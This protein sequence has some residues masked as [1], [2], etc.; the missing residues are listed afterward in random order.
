MQVRN[1]FVVVLSVLVFCGVVFAQTPW[2]DTPKTSTRDHLNQPIDSKAFTGIFDPSRIKMSHQ[3]GMSYS[4][5]GGSGITQGYY[6]NTISYRF[7][8]PVMLRMRLGVTN[9]PFAD[10]YSSGPG[11]SGMQNILQNAEFFGGAD[12]DWR[13]R[14]NVLIRLSIDRL[15]PGVYVPNRFNRFST[16]RWDG[17]PD[18]FLFNR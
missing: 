13:P 5:L 2:R 8:S 15:P 14:D 9:N 11:T 1:S 4:S 6:M 3:M 12:L 18:P 7:N 16:T 17:T 10:S